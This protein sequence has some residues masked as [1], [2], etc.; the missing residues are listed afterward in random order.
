[1]PKNRL[2]SFA[3]PIML[4]SFL[5]MGFDCPAATSEVISKAKTKEVTSKD[6]STTANE[7]LS[8][9]NVEGNGEIKEVT[10]KDNSNWNTSQLYG[11]TLG[12]WASSGIYYNADN[13]SNHSNGPVSMT[14]RSGEVELYQLDLFIEKILHKSSNW[15]IGGRFDYM[16]GTDTRYTQ[17]SGH[18][19]SNL[20]NKSNY[21]NMAMPQAYTEIYAPIGNGVTAKVGHFYTILGYESVPSGNNFFSSHSYSFKSSP[22]TTTGV[23]FNY[24]IDEQWDLHF[25]AV[26]GA[27]NFARDLGA[28]SQMSGLNW[29]NINTGTTASFSIMSGDV[30][31]YQSSQLIY[32]SAILK[33]TLGNWTYVLQNDLGTQENALGQN[34]NAGWYSLVQ[35]LTYQA[36]DHLGLGLR[37]EWFRDSNGFRYDN[38]PASYYEMTAG[39]NWE[40][41]KWL[42]VRPEVRYDWSQAQTD[43]FDNGQRANQF[44]LGVDMVVQ[45]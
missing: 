12:G 23:L 1:M 16:F 28:W 10:D 40:P 6:Y 13:P 33:Q 7:V 9:D 22:F 15:E 17:A 35:Y 39:V 43:P 27:D 37:G 2:F 42:M 45:F 44:L 25:G 4:G 20:L 3:I 34:Q 26:T 30:Y 5:L 11:I 36:M 32:Y 41:R 21:Y 18:W 38:G 8:N 19:D 29:N 31:T 24:A 14:D